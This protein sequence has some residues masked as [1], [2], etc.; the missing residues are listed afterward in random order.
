MKDII[1]LILTH[2]EPASEDHLREEVVAHTA[3]VRASARG[4]NRSLVQQAE[5]VVRQNPAAAFTFDS[6]QLATLKVNGHR[7]QAG[8]FE[9]VSIGDLKNRAQ[10]LRGENVSAQARLWVLDGTNPISDIGALQATCV[11]TL[12]QVASQFNCLEAPG[13]HGVTDVAKYL[14]DPTQ[15]P[16]ASISAFPATLLRHYYAP[17]PDGVRF[18]QQTDGQQIDLL[19][20]ACG[21]N[22]TRNGYFT[23]EGIRHPDS[24]AGVL[25]SNF[26]K[27]RVGVHDQ[28]QVVLGYNWDGAVDDSEQRNIAQVFTST[29]AGGYGAE[30]SLS[31]DMFD[32]TCRQLLRAAYLGTLLAAVVVG[33]RRVILTLIGGGV[34]CNPLELIWESIGWA[35]EE[36]GPYLSHDLSVIVNGRHLGSKISLDEVILPVVRARGGM[37]LSFDSSSLTVI[38]R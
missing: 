28:A 26:D 14:G 9:A 35:L 31:A 20:D 3:A 4:G 21:P 33:R 18:I 10:K 16:R 36:V 25:E 13:S 23:G 27:I 2:M 34:F 19:A 38:R 11:D 6:N 5:E 8:H 30:E 12:F 24:I 7:W 29:V 15:G 1:D 37:V 17:G 22:H 32:L